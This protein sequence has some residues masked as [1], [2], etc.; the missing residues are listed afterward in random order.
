MVDAA[1]GSPPDALLVI[2]P[3]CPHCPIVLQ[4][5]SEL[6]KS[7]RIGRLEVI[8]AGVH[9][10]LARSLGV[11]TVPWLRLG[12]FELE[13]LRSLAEL[14]RWA[15]RAGTP[16]GLA[17]YFR[18]LLE[19]G[20]LPKVL[21]LVAEDDS[22]LAAL[23]LLLEDPDTELAVRVGIGAVMEEFQGRAPLVRLVDDLGRL[24]HSRDAHVRGDASHY[25]GLSGS[26]HAIP[27]LQPLLTDPERQVREIAQESL[28]RL[29]PSGQR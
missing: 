27:Y 4:A 8:N 20:A 14:R 16:E 29:A 6:I 28:E 24:T 3:G 15:E 12:I 9:D 25:L 17:D 7:G 22:R 10:R 26:T 11:R 5:L 18:E 13:G 19:S 21:E 1:R 2:A 23:L